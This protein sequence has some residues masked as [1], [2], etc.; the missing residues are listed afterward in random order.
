MAV[1][2]VLEQATDR[3]RSHYGVSP[4]IGAYAPGRVEVLGNHTDYNEGFVLSAAIDYGHFFLL[5]PELDE[6]VC[7][8]VAGDL[9][10]EVAFDPV[11]PRPVKEHTWANYII[12]VFAGLAARLDRE[13]R[14]F[15]ALFFGN[16]PLGSG[17]SSSAALEISTARALA[18]FWDLDV[19]T[20]EMARIG[21]AAEHE[22]A[23]V[24]TGLLD[25]MSSLNGKR[26]HLVMSDFRT[27]EV[28]HVPLGQEARLLVCNTH[29]KHSLVDSAYNERREACERAAAFFAERLDHPVGSL[30]DVSPEEWQEHSA[31]MDEVTARRAAHIVGENDRVVR[32][33]RLLEAGRLADFGALM[34]ESHQSSRTNF[35]NSSP[36]LD[37]LVE[38]ASGI[39]VVLGARLS[40]GGF[41]GSAVM[42]L[43]PH[44]VAAVA[45]AVRAAYAGRYG[46][47]CDVLVI[48]PSDG[49]HVLEL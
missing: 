21:Q 34:Y 24:R 28:A 17:L 35:E 14:P 7:R 37:F 41:G 11:S 16:I 22:F 38:T 25:Q 23:G 15:R 42:L 4:V 19:P 1:E 30:R 29:A 40:G 2:G 36:E 8:V 26:D 49:A 27:L 48:R 18:A 45:D 12:G 44:D 10:Y 39:E 47:P 3:F 43:A 46:D 13:P 32:G 33:R 5:A 9:M 20:L 6:T 31:A